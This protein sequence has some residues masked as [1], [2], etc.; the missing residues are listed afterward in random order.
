MKPK[1]SKLKIQK[2]KEKFKIQN[3]LND[4]H[5]TNATLFKNLHIIKRKRS[6]NIMTKKFSI[7]FLATA[8][9]C[10]F[11]GIGQVFAQA[12]TGGITGVVSDATGAVVPNASVIITNKGTNATQ[13]TTSSNNGVYSFVLLQPGN[14]TVKVS[15]T[16]FAEQTIDVEVQVGRTT[17]ANFT[18]GVAGTTTEVTVTAEGVQTTASQSDAVLNETAIQNLPINGRRFQDF[19]TL[20]PSAQVEGSRGQISLSGQRGINGNVNVDGV[21]FNQTFFGGIRGGERS[22]QA[23]V[24]PQEAI[25]EFQ[26]VAS[27][28]SAEYGRSTGGIVNAV[29]KSG[30]NNLRGS[31][32]YLYR[33][34]QLARGN[35]YTQA[36]QDQRL[37]AL[38]V[39]ATLAPTQ[40][41][42]GG[43][44]GGPIIKD[45]LFYF[46]S[47][48]QQRFRAPR[49]VLFASLL[50]TNFAAG[51]RGLEAVNFLRSLEVP[52]EE[53]NDAYALLGRI[54]WNINNNNRFNARYSFSRND[55]LNA[56]ATGE[57]TFDPTR[58]SALSANGIERNRNNIGVAQL[59]TNFGAAVVNDLRLQYARE[60][61]PREANEISPNVFFGTNFGQFGSRNF[62]PTTQYDT[63]SQ[64]TDSLNYVTGNHTFKFG[65][66]YS[67]IFANQ[68]FGFNQF[69]GYLLT[70]GGTTTILRDVSNIR[71]ITTT[72]PLTFLGR[73]DNT[74]ASYSRQIGN[75]QTEFTTQELAFF[76]QD[77]WRITPKFTINYGLRAEQQ[78]NPN[79]EATNTQI[80]NVVQNTIFPIRGKG[81]DPTQIPD[82]GWQFGPRLGFAYDPEGDGKTVIRGFSGIYY[83]RTPGLIFADSI[84]NYRATPGNVST[85]LPFTGFSQANFNTFLGTAAGQQYITI[86]GC[87]LT[88]TA[89]QIAACTPNTVY[90][91][92]AIAGINLNN[93]SLG[94][95]PNVTPEQIAVISSGL[96]LSANPFVGVQITGHSEDFKNPRSYQFG[97]GV[98]RELAAN[99]VVGID[100]S[101]VKT[102]RL[103]RN[104]DI[105][106]PS[107]LTGEQ[108]RAFLQANNTV[109]NYNTM[110][111]NGTIAQILQSG[112]TY[113]AISAPGSLSFPSGS[114]TTRQRPTN[115]PA[116]NPNAANRLALG[117]VQIRDSSAKS[118]YEGVTFRMR[119]VRKWGQLNA[120]YTLSK[121][122]SDDDN[123]R[124]SGGISYANPYDFSGEY[125][126]SRLDRT[127]QF[128]ANPV[129]F[130]PFGFEV[131]SAIRLRS[132]TPINT[133]IGTDANGDR[134][135]NDRPVLNSEVEL[136]RNSFRNRSL[137]DVDMRVQKGFK[138]DERK[139]L[140][141]SAEFFN[142]FNTSNIVFAFPNT[143]STSG[144]LAQYCSTGSQLCGFDGITNINFLQIREQNPTSSNF[145]NI[146]LDTRP[147]SQVFQVQLGARFQF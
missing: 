54:D 88:G 145:G 119:L 140:V 108:Y 28:Y 100:Y 104:R 50:S 24:I 55:A 52:Y 3:I 63:R 146:N 89:A 110:V 59:I 107:P 65:G 4:L 92:F 1:F 6:K 64:V 115:D 84:N 129:F 124:D 8:I 68:Q 90:R 83:A 22:N 120:Y 103:Q 147:G 31:L 16:G 99:F 127:H 2:L 21:D 14:Y 19:V 47:Y 134:V 70:T 141:F 75:L 81:F 71:T 10:L 82:S 29:T 136:K 25:R 33:P 80:I 98:E 7:N 144:P 49:Q 40:H 66:E 12:G 42:F 48:E 67:R 128:V 106:V 133:Y 139:R 112:R 72:P 57:T 93:S 121:N 27:G 58:N 36:L 23:F 109:A 117:A 132:G 18:L 62:L 143:A 61:R 73:F 95:L 91:Q 35:E 46:A 20:T 125:G 86:T 85:T 69:G 116:L 43:S 138:F 34:E 37:T 78:Y 45:K 118:L 41:Q 15:P 13:N 76:A 105:N 87:N 131:S 135:F 79:P 97:F 137:Y 111:A 122:E 126:P 39:D 9:F 38:G 5:L 113:I 51:D 32:F 101:F 53:T 102:D 11:L 60:E 30:T 44:I 26:V 56:A 74:N 123:E 142:V 77:S 94:N 96:G 130:L 17:D 114:V